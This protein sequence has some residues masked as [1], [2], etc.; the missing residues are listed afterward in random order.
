MALNNPLG[1]TDVHV[2]GGHTTDSL[3]TINNSPGQINP[4]IQEGGNLPNTVADLQGKYNF[5]IH[6][7]VISRHREEF[8]TLSI[9]ELNGS[10]F[11]KVIYVFSEDYDGDYQFP[12]MFFNDL[13]TQAKTIHA[14]G[15]ADEEGGK[16]QWFKAIEAGALAKLYAIKDSGT[17]ATINNLVTAGAGEWAGS[18]DEL[19]TAAYGSDK[20]LALAFELGTSEYILGGNP[21]NVIVKMISL[22]KGMS[23]TQRGLDATDAPVTE[24]VGGASFAGFTH[25]TTAKTIHLMFPDVAFNVDGTDYQEHERVFRLEAFWYDLTAAQFVLILNMSKNNLE[26][27]LGTTNTFLL[28]ELHQNATTVSAGYTRIDHQALLGMYNTVPAGVQEG[29]SASDELQTGFQYAFESKENYMQI[30]RAN[31]MEITGTRLASGGYRIDDIK[32]NRDKMLRLYK[33]DKSNAIMWGKKSQTMQSDGKPLRTMSGI[34]DYELSPIKYIKGTLNRY[35]ASNY[36]EAIKDYLNEIAYSMHA[37]K[38]KSGNN[39]TSMMCSHTML[40]AL[41]EVVKLSYGQAPNAHGYTTQ[42][43]YRDNVVDF[44]IKHFDFDT[45]YGTLKFM[46]EPRLDYLTEFQ[47]P[48]FLAGQNVNPRYIMLALDKEYISTKTLRPD[49]LQGN[50]QAND[51]DLTREDIIGEQTLEML[52]PKNHSVIL[53]GIV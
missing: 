45:Q 34:F 53:T 16:Q 42:Q 41:D 25:G 12:D 33:K 7:I 28:E 48:T 37:F 47:L 1:N 26:T 31:P 27:Q 15:S 39:V 35:S 17:D 30:F 43:P 23:Y 22:L 24:A 20:A 13:R 4:H 40:R 32:R 29:S 18:L 19:A 44:G 5:D 2:Y 10:S 21:K 52:Y 36:S 9:A 50:I 51:E 11:D 46:H 3:G 49:K 38:P 8:P 6:D 14:I